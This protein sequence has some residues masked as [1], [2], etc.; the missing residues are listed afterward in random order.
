VSITAPANNAVFAAP[1]NITVTASASDAD[2]TVAKV[3]FFDGATLVGTATAAPYGVT[4]TNVAAGAHSYTARAT[5][6][7]G[8]VT[9]S[10]AVSVTV[11]TAPAVNLTAPAANAVFAAPATISLSAT[12]TDAV[13][14]ISKVDFYQGT[15][16]IGTATISPYSF[17][18]TNVAPGTYSLTA[19]AT[20]DAGGTTTSAP[21]AIKVDA[22]P[23]VNLTAPANNAVFAAPAAIALSAAA[24]D[25][26]GT[27]TKVD[28]YQGTTMIG[29]S[30][31]APYS[32]SW[33]GV[34]AGSYSLTAVATN[35]AGMTTTSSAVAIA[36]DAPPGVAL[37]GP[38]NGAS[39]TAP[40]NIPIAASASDTVGTVT[41]VDFYQGGTLITTLT[42]A[43]Y[44]FTWTGV[45]TG[46]YSLTA[47]ATNDAG[48]SATS[49]AVTI[50][51][52]SGVAQIYYIHPDHLNTPR[53]IADSTGTT[54]W[55]WDQGEP[56]GSDVPNGDPNNTGTTFDFPLRF[57]GQ[58]FDRETNLSYNFFRD[59][60]PAIGR[61]V[62]SDPIGLIG[63]LNTYAY[64]RGNPISFADPTGESWTGVVVV[65][66]VGT[67]AINWTYWNVINPEPTP[68]TPPTPPLPPTGDDGL[69]CR[70]NYGAPPPPELRIPGPWPDP[71]LSRPMQSPVGP[72]PQRPVPVSR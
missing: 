66:V 70:P 11:D 45:P 19:M 55:R 50:A 24:T 13:G 32:F 15:T 26:V 30:T 47:V 10:A 27:I 43:P 2:G 53:L 39:F 14:T 28:F 23:V 4:L 61:Y 31:A 22:A 60:D 8:A 68:G 35:D 34:A 46:S 33:T 67:W 37:T 57:A 71:R 48:T 72:P 62:Q 38:V 12:A 36:V 1:A 42:A 5:D 9:T 16:L 20:N 49:A 56:F 65:V 3:D 58:Y 17:N 54:V 21:V 69:Q 41:K 6:N 18:W 52:N 40:A 44:S 63:G 51:V 25:T 64:V 29:T 59:Y 7:N